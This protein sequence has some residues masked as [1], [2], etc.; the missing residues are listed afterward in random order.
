MA[1][2]PAAHGRG[3]ADAPLRRA[4]RCGRCRRAH[5][6]VAARACHARAMR[7]RPRASAALAGWS[8]I[9]AA[10]RRKAP[11]QP[12]E[13]LVVHPDRHHQ[14]REQPRQI[15]VAAVGEVERARRSAAPASPRR[16]A[17]ATDRNARADRD[18]DDHGDAG[19][20]E[21]RHHQAVPTDRR[22][23]AP[24]CA[25]PASRARPRSRAAPVRRTP[26]DR[27]TAASA[28]P[29]D[30]SAVLVNSTKTPP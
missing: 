6:L 16:S 19:C 27:P 23:S 8:A 15:V 21:R 28:A 1:S 12:G 14:Q 11:P 29:A 18:P 10:Q 24:I 7:S 3:A 5:E 17:A 30:A 25:A 22:A 20:I 4:S 9:R 13:P 2:A 26:P